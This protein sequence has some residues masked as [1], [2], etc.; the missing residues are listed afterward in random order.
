MR[1]DISSDSS[2]RKRIH[3]ETQALFSSKD[4]RKKN[5]MSSLSFLFGILR[6][7]VMMQLD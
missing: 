6:V 7:N 4:K 5:K 1:L 3:M 2:A